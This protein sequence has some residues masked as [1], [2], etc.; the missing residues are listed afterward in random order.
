MGV[1][2][3]RA[4]PWLAKIMS[5]EKFGGTSCTKPLSDWEKRWETRILA[6]I[7]KC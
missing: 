7:F 4:I 6:G 3:P 5:Q 2:P 1:P